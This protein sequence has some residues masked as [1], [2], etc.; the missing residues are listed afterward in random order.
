MVAVDGP[1]GPIHAMVWQIQVGRIPLYLLD[2]NVRENPPALRDITARLY[3]GGSQRRL[4]QEL[5]LGIGGMRAL[6]ALQLSHEVV[7][8]NEGHSAFASLER[9]RQ[10]VAAGHMDL[11]PPW[12]FC[13][14]PRFSPPIHR[15]RPDTTISGGYDGPLLETVRGK[16]GHQPQV[17]HQLG[18]APGQRPGNPAF[19]VYPRQ[20]HVGPL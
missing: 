14:A 12:K 9:L 4:A 2:T 10:L 18:S 8:M 17:H 11:K 19:H 3:S 16:T 1:E 5:V 20:T 7:H 6:E 13:R 15:W